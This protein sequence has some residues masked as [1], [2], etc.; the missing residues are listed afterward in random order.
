MTL[1]LP[2][3]VFAALVLVG[4]AL[5]ALALNRQQDQQAL[6]HRLSMMAGTSNVGAAS[7]SLLKDQRLSHIPLLDAILS[8]TPFV[9]PLVQMIEQA[10]LRRRVGEVLLYVFLVFLIVVLLVVLVGGSA[11]VGILFGAFAASVPL[12]VVARMRSK[13][14]I[15]FAEQLPDALDLIRA[16]LQA[17]H[18]LVSA[19]AVV[20]ETFADPVAQ[21]FRH[22]CEEV[23]LG[24]PLRDALMNLTKRVRDENLPILV[25]GIL[26]SQEVGGNLAEVVDNIGHTIRERAKLQRDVRALTAQGR[27][28]GGVLTALPFIV[29]G[30]MFLFNPKYFAPMIEETAGHYMMIYVLVSILVGH[31]VIR[32]I[33]RVPV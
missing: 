3:L 9:A 13:R 7:A 26:T 27:L 24:L 30:F 10:G 1:L 20:G 18:G 6:A 8:A 33:I 15:A 5:S 16:A 28:S 29:G 11:L 17:G 2:L 21:E 31:L 23:R 12:L 22:L 14:T 32:R 4:Y 19:C 25:I